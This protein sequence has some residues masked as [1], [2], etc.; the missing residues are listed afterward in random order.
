MTSGFRASLTALN[1]PAQVVDEPFMAASH[2]CVMSTSPEWLP[3]QPATEPAP[4][5]PPPWEDRREPLLKRI[6]GPIAVIG[7]LIAKFAVKLK[8]LFVALKGAKFLTTSGSMLVSIGAYTL[9]W[10]WRFA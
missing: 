10:G 3:P 1:C 9:I 2:T 6:F 5:A 8:F 4:A 7:V